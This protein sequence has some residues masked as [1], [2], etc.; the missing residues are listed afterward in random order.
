MFCRQCGAEVDEGKSFCTK[1][2]APAPKQVETPAATQPSPPPG[3]P[4]TGMMP[5]PPVPPGA[6]TTGPPLKKSRRTMTLVIVAVVAVI[7]IIGGAVTAIVLVMTGASG[8]SAT[9]DKFFTAAETK[10]V[11]A[12]MK[13][14]DTSYFAGDQ[15]LEKIFREGIFANI[16][17][18]VTFN[19]LGYQTTINGDKATVKVIKG[20]A[21]F[22]DGG[23]KQKVQLDKSATDSTFEFVKKNGT[24]LMSPSS[25]GTMFAARYKQQAEDIFNKD[26]DPKVNELGAAFKDVNTFI[27]SQ[28]TPSG[29][30]IQAKVNAIQPTLDAYKTEAGKAKEQY[31]KIVDLKGS[32]LKAY[33]EYAKAGIGFIDTS[34]ALFDEA[35]NLEKYVADTKLKIDANQAVDKAAYDQHVNEV[36][37]KL[38]DLQTK[39][40]KYQTEMSTAAAKIE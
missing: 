13:I 11:D 4:P 31:Q 23:K 40:E 10:N 39:M 18:G 9:L 19:G 29:A 20:T 27:S 36:S 1:C 35:M 21:T 16:P 34:I 24:W 22:D 15:E 14:V 7:L 2:G 28:P 25:F 37:Q 5:P 6:L 26:I 3:Q 30:A 38:T 12:A 33:Q 8:P 32:G 17:K